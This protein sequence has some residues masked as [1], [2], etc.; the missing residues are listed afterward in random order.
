MSRREHWDAIYRSK[1]AS[2][3]SWYQAE[4]LLSLALIQR[5][6]HDLDDPIIDVGGGAS[7]LVDALLAAGY[8]DVTVLDIA[9]PALAVARERLGE[10]AGAVEWRE[11][12]VLT[13]QLPAAGY[14]IWHDRAAFHFLTRPEDRRS[15]AA[16]LR[17]ALRPRGHAIVASFA[18]DG[19][20]RCSG[21]EVVRYSPESMLAELGEGLELVDSAREAHCTPTGATQSFIYCLFQ[22]SST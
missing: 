6:A 2:D 15:Y 13:V 12:D 14:A 11:A 20:S 5:V 16:A 21:L 1:A 22:R 4:P 17:H 9:E 10:R 19:P 18:T 7:T 3:V 8:R